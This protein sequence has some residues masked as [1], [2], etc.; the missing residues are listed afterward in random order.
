MSEVTIN[1][2]YKTTLVLV[3]TATNSNVTVNLNQGLTGQVV[4]VRDSSGKA[5]SSNP[6]TISSGGSLFN[7]SITGIT[8]TF[9]LQQ[10]YAFATFQYGS[11]FQWTILN[12]FGLQPQ[13]TVWPAEGLTVSTIR[14][15]DQIGS[16]T[17]L[18]NV[19][20]ATLLLDGEP[21]QGNGGTI[22][23]PLTLQSLKVSTITISSNLNFSS[24]ENNIRLNVSGTIATNFLTLND[25]AQSQQSKLSVQSNILYRNSYSVNSIGAYI[26][27]EIVSQLG[28]GSGQNITMVYP[29][30]VGTLSNLQNGWW[31]TSFESPLNINASTGYVSGIIVLPG[32]S[33]TVNNGPNFSGTN[34]IN[35]YANTTSLP[36][37]QAA[38]GNTTT[39]LLMSSYVLSAIN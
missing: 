32:Y 20:N 28:A 31:D 16:G 22:S 33:I 27:F 36:I 2:D 12:T 15:Y 3:N 39:T 10:A 24:T 1:T 5:S 30:Y 19:S 18:L 13:E 9:K 6:I 37:Y 34:Y 29:L 14:F 17:S 21:I 11:T 35:N 26:E 4:T 38:G 8:S 7:T 25:Q 23:D